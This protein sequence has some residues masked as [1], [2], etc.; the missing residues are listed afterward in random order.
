MGVIEIEPLLAEVS[1]E[2]PAGADVE[3]DPEYFEL[4]KLARGTPE[5]R[6]GDV[7]KP[8][9]EPVWRE[10]KEAALKLSER[11]RDVRVGMILS[12]SLLKE[13]GLAGFKDG[14]ALLRGMVER[15]W[16]QF[17]PKLDPDDNNDP[18]VRVNIF[19]GFVGDAQDADSAAD[20]YK[21]KLRLREAILT[22]S[23]QRIGKFSFRDIQVAR[24][25]VAAPA[26]P[27]GEEVKPP[28]MSIINAAFEDTTTEDLQ[29]T[30]ALLQ[31]IGE[32]LDALDAGL[33]EKVGAGS[34]PDFQPIKGVLKEIG[35]VIEE[36]LGKRGLGSAPAVDGGSGEEA[37]G[38]GGV[39]SRG[40]GISGEITS[41]NDVIR[42]LDKIC[43]Y[44][45]QYEPTSPVPIFMKRA[46]KLVTM[47]FVALM[48]DLA[49]EAMGKI[50][51]FTGEPAGEQ[52]SG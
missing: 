4:E 31:G 12:I 41:R 8:A 13:D 23:Q 30:Q 47:D 15:L 37:S 3:Y 7:V 17:Y 51:V 26:A 52:S 35:E 42:M 21:T 5:S 14:A 19:K 38:G 1:A 27:E 22:N 33:G 49:P 43:D 36:Q 9:E 11:T 2:A 48:R 16:E 18:T 25:D 29:A 24:G 46:K 44:Y 45:E 20:I 10:V 6:M 34:S 28:D 40:A 39:V 50:E 32:D